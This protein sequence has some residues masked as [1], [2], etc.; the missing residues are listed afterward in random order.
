MMVQSSLS[1]INGGVDMSLTNI[2]LI[3]D[4]KEMKRDLR[5]SQKDTLAYVYSEYEGDYLEIFNVEI[6][7]DGCIVI[8]SE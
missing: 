1:P 2:E 5:E 6:D 7:S 8:T 4:M 3:R